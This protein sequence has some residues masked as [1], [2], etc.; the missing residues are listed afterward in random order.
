MIKLREASVKGA[1]ITRQQLNQA[2]ER[3]VILCDN[4]IKAITCTRKIL[5]YKT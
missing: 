3:Q 5:Q 2:V 4:R 1:L